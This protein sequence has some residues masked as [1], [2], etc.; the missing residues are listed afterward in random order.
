[1]TKHTGITKV[2]IP[3]ERKLKMFKMVLRWERKAEW[4]LTD[5]YSDEAHGAWEMLRLLGLADEY[6]HWAD[7][8]YENEE[9]DE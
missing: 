6:E 7:S 8:Q 1:M 5:Q 3:E 9:S 2:D 4:A